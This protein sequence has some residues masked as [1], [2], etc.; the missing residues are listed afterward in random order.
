MTTYKNIPIKDI[1]YLVDGKV[2]IACSNLEKAK[3]MNIAYFSVEEDI[4]KLAFHKYP[5]VDLSKFTDGEDYSN[6][7]REGFIAGYK[8]ATKCYSEEDMFY[9]SMFVLKTTEEE[10]KTLTPKEIALKF[11]KSLKPQIESV[12]VEMEI[13]SEEDRIENYEDLGQCKPNKQQ[14]ITKEIDGVQHLV[15]FNLNYK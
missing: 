10:Q 12:D 9:L 2:T 8:Q 5:K 3:E 15:N 14:P 1:N 13:D 6:L 11:I 7:S 4:A